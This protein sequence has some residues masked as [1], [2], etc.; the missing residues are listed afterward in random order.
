MVR[1]GLAIAFLLALVVGLGGA[2]PAGAADLPRAIGMYPASGPA[3]ALLDSKVEV[4]VRVPIA[5]VIVTQR[6]Q[7]G[8]DQATE[9]TYIFPLPADAAVTA[10][11]IKTGN[12]TLR[13]AI[14]SRE[15]AQRRYE[16]AIRRGASAGLLDQERPDVFTQT[17]A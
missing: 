10:M 16:D 1:L 9:A 7:N 4:V 8:G 12:R 15:E 17:V 3:L 14:E 5:E 11:W 6:F 13:G 2:K